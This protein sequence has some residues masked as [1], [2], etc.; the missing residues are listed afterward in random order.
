MPSGN[1]FPEAAGG[2][3]GAAAGA[4]GFWAVAACC[5]DFADAA[6]ASPI[7]APTITPLRRTPKIASASGTRDTDKSGIS[8]MSIK[9]RAMA[10]TAILSIVFILAMKPQRAN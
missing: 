10:I 2:G 3:V 1:G 6:E 8:A 7:V 5:W 4:A 9:T